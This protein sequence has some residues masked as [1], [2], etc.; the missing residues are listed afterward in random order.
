MKISKEEFQIL[1]NNGLSAFVDSLGEVVLY[2]RYY[3]KENKDIDPFSLIKILNKIDVINERVLNSKS[4]IIEISKTDFYNLKYY[5]YHRLDYN[6]II[7]ANLKPIPSFNT[8]TC[9]YY[10]GR[11]YGKSEAMIFTK[12]GYKYNFKE[13]SSPSGK[14]HL[15]NYKQTLEDCIEYRKLNTA[16]KA[17]EVLNRMKRSL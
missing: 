2:L 6:V 15:R 4:F 9:E 1:I 7:S 14:I 8:M 5:M 16:Q 3:F 10:I 13:K 17:R 12:E 11:N